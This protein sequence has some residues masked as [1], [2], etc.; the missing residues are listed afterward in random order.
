M[1]EKVIKIKTNDNHIIYWTLNTIKTNKLIIFIHW[2][3]SDQNDEI[4]IRASKYFWENS[5]DS[6]KFDLY[7]E[8]ENSRKLI[9]SNIT[10]HIEDLKNVINFFKKNYNYNEINLIW[11]S[12]GGLVIINGNFFS[13]I[14]KVILWDPSIW[15]SPE[16]KKED[17]TYDKNEWIYIVNWWI[18]FKLNKKMLKEWEEGIN[19]KY[20]K[21]I[22]KN[23]F[24]IFAENSSIYNRW[25]KYIKDYNLNYTI[26]KKI[27]HNFEWDKVKKELFKQTLNFLK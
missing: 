24:F 11:H 2:L 13:R 23:T 26:I 5:Y 22:N 3:Y 25:K 10:T 15:L 14:N 12:L 1:K 8:R 4:Y 17:I 21:N 19:K 20:I 7:S 16:E 18:K 27:W 9:N 6:F